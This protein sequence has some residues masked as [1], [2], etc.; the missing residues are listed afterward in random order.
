M[1]NILPLLLVVSSIHANQAIVLRQNDITVELTPR[2]ANQ[3]GAFYEA[4]GF[5][6]AMLSVIK[7]QC[8]ITVGIH[9]TGKEKIWFELKNWTFSV[10]GKPLRREHRDIWRQ[11]W[12]SMGI[13]L[14]KQSTFRWT[15]IPEALDYLPGEKEGGNIL[16]PFTRDWITVDAVFATGNDRKG[17]PIHLHY[18]KLYCAEDAAATK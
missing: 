4:R 2:S 1:I 11:R 15:L 9:N 17:P 3:M 14:S 5:P 16:L 8:Y 13:A 6:K 12:A 7:K 10:D 18:E